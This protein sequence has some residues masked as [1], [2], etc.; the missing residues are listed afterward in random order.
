MNALRRLRGDAGEGEVERARGGGRAGAVGVGPGDF[1]RGGESEGRR[2]EGDEEGAGCGEVDYGGEERDGGGWCRVRGVRGVHVDGEGVG[3][4]EE[5]EGVAH[6]GGGD[7]ADC[8]GGLF[9]R[10][11]E[12]VGRR[13]WVAGDGDAGC[14]KRRVV[15]L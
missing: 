9:G 8:W 14:R 15:G 6:G 10:H 7:D 1:L 5:R 2:D 4:E 13:W 3:L 11:G 12:V